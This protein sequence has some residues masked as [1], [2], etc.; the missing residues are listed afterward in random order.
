MADELQVTPSLVI[1]GANCANEFSRSSGPGGQGV[2]T[3]DSRVELSF[4]VAESP[5][6]PSTCAAFAGPAGHPPRRR[7]AHHRRQRVPLTAGQPQRR[8]GT[9]GVDPA[10]RRRPAAREAPPHQALPRA[11]ERRLEAKHQ[12]SEIKRNRR[13]TSDD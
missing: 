9:P 13:S 6:I 5:S 4:D 10:H 11:K 1:A 12:R 3:T 7:R 8:P 2:N